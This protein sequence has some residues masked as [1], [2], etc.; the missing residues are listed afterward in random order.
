M[1]GGLDAR[2]AEP[3]SEVTDDGAIGVVEVVAGGE[4]FDDGD[5]VGREAAEHGV[6]QAGVQALLEEDVSGEARLHLN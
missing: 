5:A 4:D 2:V 6:Q 1:E 3:D